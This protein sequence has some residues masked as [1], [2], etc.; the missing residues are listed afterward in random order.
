MNFLHFLHRVEV[1]FVGFGQF[2][3]YE[4]V[5]VARLYVI[6]YGILPYPRTVLVPYCTLWYM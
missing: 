4:F 3:D 6:W 1:R 2:Y 5:V